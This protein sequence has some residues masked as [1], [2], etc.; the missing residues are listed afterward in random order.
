MRDTKLIYKAT[1]NKLSSKLGTRIGLKI[2][3]A[4]Y[5]TIRIY[6]YNSIVYAATKVN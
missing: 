6:L 1:D 5:N 4:E 2:V 3:T